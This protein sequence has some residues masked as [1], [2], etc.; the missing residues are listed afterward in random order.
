MSIRLSPADVPV[1]VPALVELASL[2]ARGYVR[3][4]V[5]RAEKARNSATSPNQNLPTGLELPPPQWPAVGR[6]DRPEC[7]RI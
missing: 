4:L 1:A 5:A 2:L 7:R 6:E 3:L